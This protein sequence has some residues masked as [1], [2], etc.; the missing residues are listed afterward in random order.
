MNVA[1]GLNH[2]LP[3]GDNVNKTVATPPIPLRG[4]LREPRL[5]PA[6]FSHFRTLSLIPILGSQLLRLYR[7]GDFVSIQSRE[8]PKR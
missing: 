6:G 4:R 8:R 1:G 5:P 2:T 7:S 3:W